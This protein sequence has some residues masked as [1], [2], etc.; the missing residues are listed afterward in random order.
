MCERIGVNITGKGKTCAKAQMEVGKYVMYSREETIY[1]GWS[2]FSVLLMA[3]DAQ[4]S[5]YPVLPNQ[6]F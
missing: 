4:V 5:S 2:R 1:T 3:L 6:D